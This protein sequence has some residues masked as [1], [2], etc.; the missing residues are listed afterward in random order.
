MVEKLES[1]SAE[2]LAGLRA[3][4]LELYL[5]ALKVDESVTFLA[6]NL[7]VLREIWLVA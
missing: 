6:V 4:L 7:V 1:V 3:E 5:V 2:W